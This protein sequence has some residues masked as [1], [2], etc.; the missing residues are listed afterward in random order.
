MDIQATKIE[1]VK[2][3]LNV[4]KESVLTKIKEILSSEDASNDEIVAYTSSGKP[5]SKEE[6]SNHIKN[7]SEEI[8]KGAKTYGADEVRDYVLNRKF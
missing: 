4:K 3:L 1:L 6:Y 2:Q 8:E 7:I 5:L